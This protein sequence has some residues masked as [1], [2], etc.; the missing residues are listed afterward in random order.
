MLDQSQELEI[1]RTVAARLRER[2]RFADDDCVMLIGSSVSGFGHARSDLDLLV[3][4]STAGRLPM[5]S[6][7]EG[8]RVDV[9]FLYPSAWEETKGW[10]N[11]WARSVA[12]PYQGRTPP[13]VDDREWWADHLW[14]YDRVVNSVPI[15]EDTT[16]EFLKDSSADLLSA[17]IHNY[18][19]ALCLRMARRG[20]VHLRSGNLSAGSQYLCEALLAAV[21]GVAAARGITFVSDRTV[22]EKGRRVR[23]PEDTWGAAD[24]E[25]LFNDLMRRAWGTGPDRSAEV[26]AVLEALLGAEFGEELKAAAEDLPPDGQ[27]RLHLA[28]GWK[29]QVAGGEGFLLRPDRSLYATSPAVAR[30]VMDLGGVRTL[31]RPVAAELLATGA[32]LVDPDGAAAPTVHRTAEHPPLSEACTAPVAPSPEAWVSCRIAANWYAMTVWSLSDDLYGAVESGHRN[33]VLPILRKAEIYL[34][35]MTIALKSVRSEVGRNVAM[36]LQGSALGDGFGDLLDLVGS[37]RPE[38]LR[39]VPDRAVAV[40]GAVMEACG[41]PARADMFESNRG[42]MKQVADVRVWFRVS[43]GLGIPVEAPAT[44]LAKGGDA[45]PGSSSVIAEPS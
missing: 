33:R 12:E 7:H 31:A 14:L 23:T 45:A 39:R 30:F 42:F 4:G 35:M 34:R 13:A 19:R 37:E 20:G 26:P 2:G 3:S 17:A 25:R 36:D 41:M 16:A 5:H 8:R 22:L 29:A 40:F 24:I 15:T 10:V 43:E 11:T 28:E 18:S 6:F 44:L 27:L 9:D 32:V 38:D 21:E 1:A